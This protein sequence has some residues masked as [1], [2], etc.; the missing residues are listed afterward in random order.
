M[1]KKL[2]IAA[3]LL[4]TGV[5]A[6]SAL[7]T[8]EKG[9]YEIATVED[10]EEFGALVNS[11]ST[12]ICGVLTADLD[13]FNKNHISIGTAENP[14]KGV[15]DGHYFKIRSLE[16]NEAEGSDVGF[17][18][19]ATNGARFRNIII[20][21]GSAVTGLNNVAALL[22]K[23]VAD[24]GVEMGVIEFTCVGNEA[25]VRAN[26]TTGDALAGGIAGKASSRIAYR[27]TN[28]YNTGSVVGKQVGAMTSSCA[29]ADAKGCFTTTTI[30]YVNASGKEANPSPIAQILVCGLQESYTADGWNGYNFFFGGNAKT[31]VTLYQACQSG[32]NTKVPA[33]YDIPADAVH[34]LWKVFADQWQA[35][36]KMCWYL[37]NRSSDN[38]IWG[39]EIDSDDY[40]SFVPGTPVVVQDGDSY[41]NT[42]DVVADHFEMPVPP[43]TS[44][45]EN[46][47]VFTPAVNAIYTIGGVKVEKPAAPGIYVVN[48]KK[49]IVQ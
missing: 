29:T 12:D 37:N 36:G 25:D 30:K 40:P 14:F 44:G 16:I 41:K 18:G 27:F 1:M 5:G 22:G 20:E 35:T 6:A 13:Y 7:T 28:C 49:M 23:A 3:V 33:P 45:V 2:L 9:V 10:M 17:F 38:P 32:T 24:D 31:P 15:F 21:S 42:A 8:N 39:Q 43:Q 4:A 26:G 46:V 47:S 48:G 19:V 34:P 11:G